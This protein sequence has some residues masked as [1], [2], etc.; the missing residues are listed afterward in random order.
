MVKGRR[1][2]TCAERLGH[3]INS[4][5]KPK[6]VGLEWIPN[7]CLIFVHF[8]SL[9]REQSDNECEPV[10]T[11][12]IFELNKDIRE[13][14]HLRILSCHS[15]AKAHMSRFLSF[16]RAKDAKNKRRRRMKKCSEFRV[17]A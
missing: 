16:R 1:S 4:H 6:W 14:R 3:M 2:T 10:A 13:L 11:S 7:T 9:K 8:T 5:S 17:C 12:L 15:G